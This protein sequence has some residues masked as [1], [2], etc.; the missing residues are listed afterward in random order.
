MMVCGLGLVGPASASILDLNVL[1]GVKDLS[2]TDWGS[3]DTQGAVGVEAAVSVPIV[4]IVG[5]YLH[6]QDSSDDQTQEVWVGPGMKFDLPLIHFLVSGGPDFIRA[7]QGQASTIG[8]P[9]STASDNKWGYYVSGSA[10]FKVFGILN[11]GAQIHYSAATVN[12]AGRDVKAGGIS[13]LGL[14][15]ISL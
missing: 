5:G 13:Y 1:G 2:H 10:F 11:L 6:S 15:G 4:S 8:M 7:K 12:L 9:V 3:Q 14:V